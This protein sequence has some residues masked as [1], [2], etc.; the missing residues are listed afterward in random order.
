MT[1]E[2][3]EEK[4]KAPKRNRKAAIDKSRKF[5]QRR[6]QLPLRE[7]RK[8]ART[9]AGNFWKRRM[10]FSYGELVSKVGKR[11]KLS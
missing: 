3:K 2:V 5:L 10:Q 11:I 8:Y 4:G 6:A 7:L 9:K 1:K